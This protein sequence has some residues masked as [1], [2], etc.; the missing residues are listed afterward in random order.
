[1]GLLIDRSYAVGDF[2]LTLTLSLE[3]EGISE[4]RSIYAENK[5]EGRGPRFGQ[6][7]A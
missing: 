7:T 6:Q 5:I 4:L 2:T 3:G 1:M